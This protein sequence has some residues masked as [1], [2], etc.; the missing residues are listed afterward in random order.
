MKKRTGIRRMI[1]VMLAFMLAFSVLP[2]DAFMVEALAEEPTFTLGE[3]HLTDSNWT[4]DSGTGY[5]QEIDRDPSVSIS[6]TTSGLEALS[7]SSYYEA[8]LFVVPSKLSTVQSS[9]NNLASMNSWPADSP[10]RTHISGLGNNY[11]QS[12]ISKRLVKNSGGSFTGMLHGNF[13]DPT[14][15]CIQA[16]DVCTWQ[17]ILYKCDRK[18]EETIERTE[19]LA[20]DMAEKAVD[21]SVGLPYMNEKH[22]EIAYQWPSQDALEQADKISYE[23]QI[24][25]WPQD[26]IEDPYSFPYGWVNTVRWSDE[27]DF[28]VLMSNG[29]WSDCLLEKN[30]IS[31]WFC[32]DET[33]GEGESL[34]PAAGSTYTT[35]LIINKID[36]TSGTPVVTEYRRSPAVEFIVSEGTDEGS[37]TE[38]G[39]SSLGEPDTETGN[40]I[41]TSVG[42]TVTEYLERPVNLSFTGTA[43]NSG[44]LSWSIYT[45]DQFNSSGENMGL[46]L[47]L[48][49]TANGS[50]ASITGTPTLNTR[51]PRTV[52]IT[53]TETA[54]STVVKSTKTFTLN[55]DVLKPKITSPTK[56]SVMVG[57]PFTA[58]LS[59]TPGYEENSLSWEYEGTLPAGVTL[60]K[61]NGTLSGTIQTAGKYS[62]TLALLENTSAGVTRSSVSATYTITATVA[63]HSDEKPVVENVRYDTTD[64]SITMDFSTDDTAT[65]YFRV[66][67]ITENKPEYDPEDTEPATFSKP[68]VSGS[69][70][71]YATA[72]I[73]DGT[74]G[75]TFD[76]ETGKGRIKMTLDE[77]TLSQG[78][79]N[80]PAAGE[81]YYFV[82]QTEGIPQSG[83]TGLGSAYSSNK[84][85]K[86][87]LPDPQDIYVSLGTYQDDER[88][89]NV[90]IDPDNPVLEEFTGGKWAV[91]T[92]RMTKDTN[93]IYH[94]VPLKE[95]LSKVASGTSGY[96]V[97]GKDKYNRENWQWCNYEGEVLNPD[98]PW[99]GYN[100]ASIDASMGTIP[101]SVYQFPGTTASFEDGMKGFYDGEDL[102]IGIQAI[103]KEDPT[104]ASNLVTVRVPLEEASFYKTFRPSDLDDEEQD[105]DDP[106]TPTPTPT[107]V[108]T[109]PRL[110][111]TSKTVNTANLSDLTI[112]KY[113]GSFTFDSIVCGDNT[114]VKGTDYTVTKTSVVLKKAYLEGLAGGSYVFNF[115]Y[116]G[117]AGENNRTPVDP[118]YVLTIVQ[119]A[120]PV[121]TVRGSD[122]NALTQGTDFGVKWMNRG[123]T[124]TNL[125][126]EKGTKLDYVI[127]PKDTLKVDGV[128]YYQETTGRVTINEPGQVVDVNLAQRGTV[129]IIPKVGEKVL[130][131]G[132]TVNWYNDSN[133]RIGS[134]KVEPGTL[135]EED[136]SG[137]TVASGGGIGGGGEEPETVIGVTSPLVPAGTGKLKYEIVMNGDNADT[138]NNV[139]KTAT[140]V[141]FGNKPLK[142]NI[143]AKNNIT[144]TVTGTKKSGGEVAKDDYTVLWY[145]AEVDENSGEITSFKSTGNAGTELKNINYPAGTKL[146]YEII[147]VDYS[148]NGQTEHNW[149]EFH[150]MDLSEANYVTVTDGPQTVSANSVLRPVKEV[151]LSGVVTN[152]KSVGIGNFNVSASQSPWDGYSLQPSTYWYKNQLDKYKFT[153]ESV[154]ENS[155]SYTAT[156][157]DFDTTVTIKDK[158]NNFDT[159]YRFAKAGDPMTAG[160]VE[161]TSAL[162]PEDIYIRISRKTPE[163]DTGWHTGADGQEVYGA[164]GMIKDYY[165]SD[166]EEAAYFEFSLY[167]ETQGKA[168]PNEDYTAEY[169]GASSRVT[170]NRERIQGDGTNPGTGSVRMGDTLRLTMT[171]SEEN[172]ANIH[173]DLTGPFTSE[174]TVKKYWSD[175]DYRNNAYQFNF[176]YNAWGKVSL[177]TPYDAYYWE[178]YGLYDQDGNLSLSGRKACWWNAAS[179]EAE[180]GTYTLCIWRETSWINTAPATL[181]ELKELLNENEYQARTVTLKNG[182]FTVPSPAFEKTVPLNDRSLFTDESGFSQ[183]MITAAGGEETQ[184]RLAYHVNDAIEQANPNGL[185]AIRVNLASKTPSFILRRQDDH[186]WESEKLEKYDKYI[187]L[188]VDGVL[189]TDNTVR[190]NYYSYN[191][192]SEN[193]NG[194]VVY[195]DK[196]DGV[197]YFSLIGDAFSTGTFTLNADG[198]ICGEKDSYG[199]KESYGSKIQGSIGST[200]FNVVS[201]TNC[202][203]YFT[204]DYLRMPDNG[205]EERNDYENG[206]WVY[207]VPYKTVELYMDDVKIDEKYSND[208]GMAMFSVKMDDALKAKFPAGWS[209]TGNHSIYAVTIIEE[210]KGET[211]AVTS[212]SQTYERV[213]LDKTDDIR[214]AQLTGLKLQ[215]TGSHGT[216]PI[217]DQMRY[218]GTTNTDYR[219]PNTIYSYYTV[220]AGA[221][222][223]YDFVAIVENPDWVDGDLTLWLTANTLETYRIPLKRVEGTNEYK[224]DITQDDLNFTMWEVTITSKKPTETGEAVDAQT[225][226][227]V[228]KEA[229]E[230]TRLDLADK[231]TIVINPQTGEK[232]TMEDYDAWFEDT[233]L[234]DEDGNP[235]SEEELMA[236]INEANAAELEKSEAFFTSMAEIT[237]VPLP[238]GLV[239]DGSDES[240]AYLREYLGIN[241]IYPLEVQE[242]DDE[243]MKSIKNQLA[244]WT[245]WEGDVTTMMDG[246]ERHKFMRLMLEKSLQDGK[247]HAYS[248]DTTIYTKNAGGIPDFAVV[249][250]I[251]CGESGVDE[252]NALVGS[253]VDLYEYMSD[254]ADVIEESGL[255]PAQQDEDMGGETMDAQ[256][257]P[258]L[259]A[260][261][262]LE[263]QMRENDHGNWE[264]KAQSFT[265]ITSFGADTSA[266]VDQLNAAM[267]QNTKNMNN[268]NNTNTQ[269]MLWY[270]KGELLRELGCNNQ[271]AGAVEGSGLTKL[272]TNLNDMIE[273]GQKTGKLNAKEINELKQM[274]EELKSIQKAV[275]DNTL[276]TAAKTEYEIAKEAKET[277][278]LTKNG[279]KAAGEGLKELGEFMKDTAK[280]TAID[281]GKEKLY[282]GINKETSYAYKANPAYWGAKAGAKISEWLTGEE[283]LSEQVDEGFAD[284]EARMKKFAV[285]PERC[286][287]EALDDRHEEKMRKAE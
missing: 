255:V 127:T 99:I 49:F 276:Y 213:C 18:D 135:P 157:Y 3:I 80:L 227:T 76:R 11:W 207:S 102:I 104:I 54:G 128:Q 241:V 243:N 278:D 268:G 46:P 170:F 94:V 282:E 188:Y 61:E 210:A 39:K 182:E 205:P 89:F 9:L 42:S 259:E 51:A 12:S 10:K 186:N 222:T 236:M 106:P 97:Y 230:V 216:F 36:R 5:V 203:L 212:R 200:V 247:P 57:T 64:N 273:T 144:L 13:V 122:G 75:V 118:S 29:A 105:P 140:D 249:S 235:K 152:G 263:A 274:K 269:N 113:D 285:D 261:E 181:A 38:P 116:T 197:I 171:V 165:A 87:P 142:V 250:V 164:Y 183:E 90:N 174:V 47:G 119:L 167:N 93:L 158:L 194:F 79:K 160:D 228:G 206:M 242:N 52:T 58:T 218:K 221:G 121:L 262:R 108:V 100:S 35:G 254:L 237:G 258:L 117:T 169:N 19:V 191:G 31:A 287:K 1:A 267:K 155:C 163:Y 48:S 77:S 114:L 198:W 159:A 257:S 214:P 62:F 124:L 129:T 149:L 232:M 251:D 209:R 229:D 95:D 41:S 179:I 252:D 264:A 123:T 190:L 161:M 279:L 286:I 270:Q 223:G 32:N 50:T 266:K 187:N 177:E 4:T 231:N 23:G 245:E 240:I 202:G 134:Q 217:R 139:K 193:P 17:L 20:T 211:P 189:D 180:A 103:S 239:F 219:N 132:F 60:D 28:N 246:S 220:Q 26:G 2:V 63:G 70:Y 44:T 6:W 22:M 234:E 137:E 83:Q 173:A 112:N 101:V 59:G 7:G 24:F 34:T 233:F 115:H 88:E 271:D 126:V 67:M 27:V 92:V 201:S 178:T 30:G 109:Q 53:L 175:E 98:N 208:N 192:L 15:A 56:L 40:N 8:E 85:L 81:L 195:T 33:F 280:D 260:E 176:D 78:I 148:K 141:S 166:Y 72:T 265:E 138:Y 281:Y 73:S 125:N 65:G 130:T 184:F 150:P 284:A 204:S 66:Y 111:Q 91:A 107:P 25:V 68:G 256:S 21:W 162:L 253:G 145:T 120:S 69:W 185:Y 156:V 244:E 225:L 55:V 224:G 215:C 133:N 272:M 86:V 283:G 43:Q 154:S 277:F 196:P 74:G 172:R 275:T 168:V 14:N 84:Y 96:V 71:L 37:G 226:E 248:I 238:E 146:Y 131:G 147:P 110:T 143:N 136:L 199:W 153:M 45:T 16:E 82:L 151:T